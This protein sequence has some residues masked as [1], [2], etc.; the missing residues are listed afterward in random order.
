[1]A[2]A[3]RRGVAG[4]FSFYPSKNLGAAGDGGAITTSDPE[5][6]ERLRQL[7]SHGVVAGRGH[8]RAGT[9]SRLDAV[10]AAV[11]RAKLPYLKGWTEARVRNARIYARELA[12]CPGIELPACGEDEAVVWNQY[13]VRCREPD[14]VR[15]ALEAA[16]IEWRRYYTRPVCEEPGLGD[17]RCPGSDFPE[18][19][20]ACVESLSIPVR[21]SCSPELIREI[22]ATIRREL[23]AG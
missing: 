7:R 10:Q 4:C 23:D 11:L 3:R 16:G 17:L 2:P 1:M 19:G 22:A 8:V 14:R 20:R 13:T 12:D 15:S 5:L 9:T 21:G 18:A 6:V